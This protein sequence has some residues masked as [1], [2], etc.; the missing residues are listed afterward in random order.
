MPDAFVRP[1]GVLWRL[2]NGRIRVA[3]HDFATE[4]AFELR[5]VGLR[6]NVLLAMPI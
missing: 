3:P 1:L 6:Q 2:A 4:Y 5:A